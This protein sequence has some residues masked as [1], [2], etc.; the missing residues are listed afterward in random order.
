MKR[1]FWSTLFSLT[2]LLTACGVSTPTPVSP[3]T[4]APVEADVFASVDVV[5]A[6]AVVSP[7][8]V[9][10]LGFTISGLVKEVAVKEGASVQ[11]GQT[12][13][14]LDAPELEFAVV[15]ADSAYRS[16]SINAELQNA[17]QAKVVNPNNGHVTF[18]TLPK[19]LHLIALA[20]ADKAQSSLEVA[21]ANLAQATLISPFDGTVAS[22]NVLSGQLIQA[23]QVLIT[24]ASL[25][26][27]QIETT[28]LSERDI[29]R[30]KIG[31]GVSVYFKA[32]DIT[33]N[34]K[35]IRISPVAGSVGGDVVY[36]VT[37]QL[38]EQPKGLLWGMTAEVEITTAP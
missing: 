31:Q 17:D 28:D 8:Q 1:I 16:A 35:V 23:D 13:I 34:G 33:V 5:I 32:L 37:I 22:V 14:L 4:S 3:A 36:P 20:K 24:L 38:D 2:I 10:E 18:V 12:L 27:L 29:S 7:A 9:I 19:E 6:S 30:V 26:N 25:N 11:S 21:K 15:A